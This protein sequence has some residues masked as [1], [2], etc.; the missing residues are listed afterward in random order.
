MWNTPTFGHSPVTDLAS[1][2]LLTRQTRRLG[3]ALKKKMAN[4]MPWLGMVNQVSKQLCFHAG[5]PCL[6]LT[7]KA[8]PIS[9]V[10][11]SRQVA[12]HM[13]G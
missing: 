9:S 10:P 11:F 2:V 12:I 13:P 3:T 7:A 8:T 6:G 1:H 4:Q 5:T